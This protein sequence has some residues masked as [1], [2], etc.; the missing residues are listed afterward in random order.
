MNLNKLP[1]DQCSAKENQFLLPQDGFKQNMVS[2]ALQNF[3]Q[4]YNMSLIKT[5]KYVDPIRW[6]DTGVYLMYIIMYHTC[7]IH[8]EKKHASSTIFKQKWCN[9]ML[10]GVPCERSWNIAPSLKDG[11]KDNIFSP[12][13]ATTKSCKPGK[14][15]PVNLWQIVD[16]FC[17]PYFPLILLMEEIWLTSWGWLKPCK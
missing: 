14:V 13:G 1:G 5:S 8:K 10:P 16:D 15:E 7:Y 9:E 11:N 2:Q 4:L 12:L 17:V 6:R 3:L